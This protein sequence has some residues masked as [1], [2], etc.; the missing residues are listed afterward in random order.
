MSFGV[1]PDPECNG[2]LSDSG[3]AMENNTIIYQYKNGVKKQVFLEGKPVHFV[4]GRQNAEGI[5]IPAAGPK[6]NETLSALENTGVLIEYP[7]SG[8]F[9]FE[10]VSLNDVRYTMSK[11]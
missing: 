5:W 3:W 2:N 7:V 11:F 8:E 4:K 6:N 9:M 1:D 10:M